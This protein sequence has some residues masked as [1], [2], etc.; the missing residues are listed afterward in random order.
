MLMGLNQQVGYGGLDFYIE[1]AHQQGSEADKIVSHLFFNGSV[2]TTHTSTHRRKGKSA[3]DPA[4]RPLLREQHRRL[5]RQLAEGKFDRRI[6][7]TPG[8]GNFKRCP[9]V[10][11]A[12]KPPRTA[13]GRLDPAPRLTPRRPPLATRKLI[14]ALEMCCQAREQ[15]TEGL[16]DQPDDLRLR[17]AASQIEQLIS[18]LTS[19]LKTP[20]A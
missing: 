14:L 15:I 18:K 13:A 12:A 10:T 17:Q 7:Q 20:G 11:G 9:A 19:D 16:I 3:A 8:T 2:I 4:L 1:T 5:L 6:R